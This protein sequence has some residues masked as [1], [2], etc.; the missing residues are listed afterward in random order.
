MGGGLGATKVKTDFA[1]I[2]RKAE[3]RAEQEERG[4]IEVENATQKAAEDAERAEATL[5]LAYRYL[6]A[7]VLFVILCCI[8]V[9][10][11]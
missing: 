11:H 4:R 6:F 1:A 5:R 3:E 9:A 8:F 10:L 7:F 2:E